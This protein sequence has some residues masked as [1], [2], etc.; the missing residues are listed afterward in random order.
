MSSEFFAGPLAQ[1]VGWSLLHLVWEATIVA[2]ILAATLALM[3]RR[4]AN[5]RYLVSCAALALLPLL[6]V[7]TAYRSYEAPLQVS[8][9]A[10]PA[11]WT[12]QLKLSGLPQTTGAVRGV[13]EST[14]RSGSEIV[15][16]AL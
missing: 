9:G 11:L 6:A 2:A 8:T 4:S 13:T 7:M 5:A 10:V 16:G 14:T 1:A 15:N 12:T 3:T